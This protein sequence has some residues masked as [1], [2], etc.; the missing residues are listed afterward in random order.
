MITI[1]LLNK[2]ALEKFVNSK[3]YQAMKIVPISKHRAISHI[4]NPRVQK[5]DV[6]LL[7]AMEEDVMLGYLG[8]LPDDIYLK[9]G[10]EHCGWLSCLWVDEKQ[11]GKKIAFNLV[12]KAIGV[13]DDKIL[14]TEF[15]GPAKRLYDKTEKFDSLAA[16][17]GIRLYCRANFTKILPPKNPIFETIKPLLKVTDTIFNIVFDLRFLVNST[18]FK[19]TE[20]CHKIDQEII[21]F[22]NTRQENQLFKRNQKELQW[23]LNFPWVLPLDKK[24]NFSQKY[25]FSDFDKSFE[26]TCVKIRNEENILI[27]FVIFAKRNN[28]L[29]I[30][31]YYLEKNNEKLIIDLFNSYFRKWK[32]STVTTFHRDL[33]SILNNAKTTALYKKEIHRNYIITKKLKNKMKTSYFEIQDGDADC[34]FT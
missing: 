27:G 16:N 3:T 19:N 8:V 34:I 11:R 1:E 22:I 26:F 29:K 15:T 20:E 4:N 10:N 33:V 31:Y 23:I 18:I 9:E 21:D 24:E 17:Q 25:H 2:E 5:E 7:L 6:L 13:W 14:I 30:P 12:Q 32:V 28:H